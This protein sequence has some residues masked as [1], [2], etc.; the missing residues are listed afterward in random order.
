MTDDTGGT[1]VVVMAALGVYLLFGVIG[2]LIIR[3]VRQE[4]E[5]A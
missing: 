2:Y 4:V 3:K 5:G 1:L